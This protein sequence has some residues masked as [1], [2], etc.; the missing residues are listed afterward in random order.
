MQHLFATK[1]PI[2]LAGLLLLVY[3]AQG[4]HF[5]SANSQT[6]DEAVHLTGG[7][8][9]L[10]TGDFRLNSEHPPLI[11]QLCA[12][13]VYLWYRV[14]FEPNPSLWE[15]A[16]SGADR[17]QWSISRDFLYGWAVTADRMLALGRIPNLLLGTLLVVLIGWWA[18]RLWGRG[19]AILGTSL[20]AFEPNLIAHSS[21]ITG[22]LGITLF[23]F[24]TIY[25]MWEYSRSPSRRL[26]VAIGL[27]LGLALAS[28]FS[29]VLVA[30]IVGMVA[31]I[32]ILCGG[33]FSLGG[34]SE[35]ASEAPLPRRSQ[36]AL[37][38]L[39]RI[40]CIAILVILP[41]YYFQGF[42][43]WTF[44]L[45]TQMNQQTNGKESFFFGE[46]S[47]FG[48]PYYFPVSF[49]I[50]TPVGSLALILTSFIFFRWGKPLKKQDAVFLLA[51]VVIYM[52]ALAR[53][54]LNIGFRY[55]L[56]IYPFLFVLA[57][58]LATMKFR[59]AWS[60]AGILS[61]AVL[62]TVA[63]DLRIAPHQLAYF[64]E[65][66]G[67]PDKGYL[68]LSDSNIDWGQDLRGLKEYMDRERLPMIYLCYYGTAPPEYYGIRYQYIPGFGRLEP[69]A[70]EKMPKGMNREVLAISVVMLQGVHC[71]D[72]N[73][74]RWLWD[75]QPVAK[76]G[77]SIFLY[78]LT[79]DADAHA[80]L[81]N[82]YSKVGV[83]ELEDSE[84]QIA[85]QIRM[86]KGL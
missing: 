55:A 7:Y 32:H 12:L 2:A 31:G 62:C 71:Q 35:E 76:V 66:V 51:P 67:G 53:L 63:S 70:I 5:I 86:K 17:P 80:R 54:K 61:A 39:L 21:L 68:Y 16:K 69:P 15:E 27:S 11:K 58:R 60:G 57:S 6:F 13:P 19:A 30:G 29:G 14:P 42:S 75:R 22:D 36:Q 9:Y 49:L 83:A 45:R 3:F 4:L 28:K 59:P 82:V 65:L 20:A 33:S 46:Y 34:S 8:S 81:A 24:L 1:W 73:L 50:K 79:G 18:Y 38:P 72:K 64:N 43:S 77:Y 47:T 23:M 44:G 10:A 48:W 74:F 26:L 85:K 78:D 84:K 56:P 41:F 52:L 40:F 37:L 25:L